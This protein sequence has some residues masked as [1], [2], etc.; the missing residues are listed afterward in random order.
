MVF[1]YARDFDAVLAHVRKRRCVCWSRK[2]TIENP[3][4]ERVLVGGISGV[5]YDFYC[6]RCARLR[7]FT[8][9]TSAEEPARPPEIRV[10]GLARTPAEAHLFMDL[11]PCSGCGGEEFER[12][13]TVAVVKG[14]LCSRYSGVC[15]ECGSPREFLF[16]L[17]D[18]TPIPNPAEPSF[19]GE[20]PSELLDA[21]EWMWVAD[22]LVAGMPAEPD[23]M[24][25]EERRQACRDLLTAAAAV[26]EVRKFV[27]F[28]A[29]A[30][31]PEVLWTPSGRAVYTT[32]PARFGWQRLEIVED[33]Y[34]D[35]ALAFGE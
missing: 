5:R 13:Y 30:V 28:G 19:G 31:S 32:D 18:V 22:C 23:G 1:P 20:L 4:G 17:P 11:H 27:A 16:R 21:G 10:I 3:A 26:A 25:A 9:R 2:T 34:R 33:T 15:P 8:F 24:N 6:T 7:E 29:D 35:L 14:E 12:N